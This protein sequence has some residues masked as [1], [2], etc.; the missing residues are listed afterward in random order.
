MRLLYFPIIIILFSSVSCEFIQQEIEN[1]IEDE[2]QKLEDEIQD[3]TNDDGTLLKAY[4]PTQSM[5]DQ[6]LKHTFYSLSYCTKNKNAE[7]VAYELTSWKVNAEKAERASGFK[8]DPLWEQTASDNDFRNSGYDRGHLLPAEDMDFSKEGMEETFFLTNVSP[9][10]PDFNR[11]IWKKLENHVRKWAVENKHI[12]IITGPIL[13]K[14]LPKESTIGEGVEV[15]RE[16]YKVILDYTNPEKKGIAFIMD[17][18]RSDEGLERFACPIREV[19]ER[20]GINFFPSLSA[21]ES[22]ALEE[23]FDPSLWD[24]D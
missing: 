14:R 1:T 20:T 21:S 9:Q 13:R 11:G 16:F 15:P 10:L 5:G 7:W 24:M 22:K 8:T 6:L 19:E 2:I 23:K 4:L 17:N 18:E 3:N 12:Y